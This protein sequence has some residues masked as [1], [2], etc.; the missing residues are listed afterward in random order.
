MRF[1][2]NFKTAMLLGLLMGLCLAVGY[3][4]SG[5]RPEGLVIG[6]LFGAVGNLI[7]FFFSDKIALAA[8]SAQEVTREQAPQ[9]FDMVEQLAG[10]AGACTCARSPPPTRSPP[11]AGH[12]MRPSPSHKVCSA[13]RR[14][15][16]RAS[17]RTSCRT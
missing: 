12:I 1:L 3:F 9:L 15:K 16:W 17:W 5:G 13:F 7:A 14:T 2:N 11:A 6:F 8:M 10:R 4:V